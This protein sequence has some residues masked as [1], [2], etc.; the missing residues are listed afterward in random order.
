MKI[1]YLLQ[2][3]VP[4]IRKK[5][6]SGAANHVVSVI[7]EL[8]AAGHRV[9]LLAKIDG[10]VYLSD[11][12]KSF[13]P[14]IVRSLDRGLIKLMER[15]IRRIQHEFDLPYANFFESLRFA[16]ACRQEIADFDIYFERMGWMGYGGG[17]AANWMKI[18]LVLEV[19]GDHLD[20]F[21]SQG[22]VFKRG[23]EWISYYVMKKAAKRTAHVVTTGEGWRQRYIERWKVPLSK[24][25]VIENGSSLVDLLPRKEL[26]AFNSIEPGEPLQIAYCGGFEKWHGV[27]I[28]VR[29]VRIAIDRGCNLHVTLI[30]SGSEQKNIF[31][32]IRELDLEESFTFT[33]HL[34]LQGTAQYL[35][36]ANIGVSPYCGR[37]EFSGLK[38]LDY[39][40]AGLATIASGHEGQPEVITHGVN[41]WIVPSCDVNALSD[42][43][44]YLSMNPQIVREMG[45]QARL[46]AEQS[47]RWKN[48]IELLEE[49]FL[50]ILL[51]NNKNGQL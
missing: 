39:K 9:I 47:H 51:E 50:S 35:A 14:V 44:A 34:D 41:G 49:L 3:G 11:N 36:K 1:A 31:E 22:L 13:N 2:E 10:Q 16:L 46:E 25:S 30:G 40:A 42:A 28:L 48:T 4:D 33:G 15:V 26:Q 27:T 17:L 32:L 20:E 29:A 23:Q 43:I 19:N 7:Q 21:K 8:K 5:T 18:P 37:V 38:L 12:L 6:L 45:Q 24:V